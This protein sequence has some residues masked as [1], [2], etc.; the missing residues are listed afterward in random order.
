MKKTLIL[1]IFLFAIIWQ[2]SQAQQMPQYS[3][4][5]FNDFCINP[6]VAGTKSSQPIMA[7]IRNQW[8]G[9]DDAPITQ[10]I[11]F[12][13]SWL[14]KTGM[15]GM[16]VNDV[17]GPARQ[18]SIQLAY[19]HHIVLKGE[20]YLSL[21]LSGSVAQY[22]LDKDAIMLDDPNDNAILGGKEEAIV[23]DAAFGVY[24]Y[25]ERFY[26]GWS[27]PQL[28]ENSIQFNSSE[29]LQENKLVRHYFA[30][31]GYRF[32]AG[33]NIEIE[34]SFL[35]KTI[36]NAPFQLDINT[37]VIIQKMAWLGCSYRDSES[38]VAMAGI[39]FKDIGLGY[40][41]DFTLTNIKNHSTGSHEFFLS[42]LLPYKEV[43]PKKE[44]RKSLIN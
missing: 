34:P 9:L 15:G 18:T 38:I 5:M 43:Q 22:V 20:T 13:G 12:H 17:T 29:T 27:I 6:A 41:F 1:L 31:A 7:M 23:P 4:Y 11:S 32:N 25:G 44:I 39:R 10:T 8:V 30:N 33:E 14:K 16:I 21:G 36:E 2:S 24:I 35:F 42:Y 19:A 28:F 37:K 40:S 3:Q 26:V